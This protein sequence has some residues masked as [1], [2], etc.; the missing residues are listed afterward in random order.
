M[1]DTHGTLS[2]PKTSREEERIPKLFVDMFADSNDGQTSVRRVVFDLE[3]LFFD[4]CTFP[5]SAIP[6]SPYN[7]LWA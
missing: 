5:M 4:T 3:L 6:V 1:K 7:S 2:V